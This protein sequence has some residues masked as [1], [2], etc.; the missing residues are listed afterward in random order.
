M[1]TV[2]QL[3]ENWI[4][5]SPDHDV[6]PILVE[7]GAATT[8]ADFLGED[9]SDPGAT[10]KNIYSNPQNLPTAIA[11]ILNKSQ[12]RANFHPAVDTPEEVKKT[13]ASYIKEIDGNPFFHIDN[14][15]HTKQRYDSNDYNKLIDN[16]VSLYDGVAAEDKNKIKNSIADMA[17]SVFSQ[18]KAEQWKN[19][20]SQSTI[21][22]SDIRT[23][24]LYIFYTTLYMKHEDKGKAGVTNVQEYT[25]NKATYS[26]LGDLIIASAEQLV[27][28]EKKNVDDWLTESTS[29]ERNDPKLCFK[30]QPYGTNAKEMA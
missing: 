5:V 13:Y 10:G 7:E 29:P 30:V 1:M 23:P 3:V 18:A 6:N 28:L 24:K 9:K 15:E 20:F 16:V 25:V 8:M 4:H 12:N 14:N 19:L 21:D 2:K 27:A 22:Y 11:S 17:K 26:I